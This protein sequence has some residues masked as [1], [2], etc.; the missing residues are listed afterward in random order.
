MHRLAVALCASMV[1]PTLSA[2]VLHILLH[3]AG[4]MPFS[5]ALGIDKDLW[6]VTSEDAQAQVLRVVNIRRHFAGV[7][8]LHDMRTNMTA[9]GAERNGVSVLHAAD[10]KV[11]LGV[12]D[13]PAVDHSI[14]GAPKG[15]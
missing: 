11:L 6:E 13:V 10:G 2:P 15:A 12:F 7:A 9:E 4:T 8:M 14:T 5:P 3:A 1:Q